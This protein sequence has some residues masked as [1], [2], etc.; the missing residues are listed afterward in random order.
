MTS[1]PPNSSKDLHMRLGAPRIPIPLFRAFSLE[2]KEAMQGEFP[3]IMGQIKMDWVVFI[4][5]RTTR[6][7]NVR[8]KKLIHNWP[9]H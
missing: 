9:I 8:R 7:E 5:G 6:K 3:K 4:M 2:V 1:A